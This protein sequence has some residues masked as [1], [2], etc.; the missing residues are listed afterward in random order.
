MTQT[1]GSG[2][3][4]IRC[5][6]IIIKDDRV[7]LIKRIK[8][9]TTYWVFPGGG[10]EQGETPEEGLKR[11]IYEELGLKVTSCEKCLG[12]QDFKANR[13]E[14]YFLTEVEDGKPKLTVIEKRRQSPD[15]RYELV[16]EN[17]SIL[18][19]PSVF[20]VFVREWV[21]EHLKQGKVEAAH[22]ANTVNNQ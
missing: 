6:A 2:A 20:P 17:L 21:K 15:N 18:D 16:W 7:L 10:L 11:E 3:K 13:E 8:P 1:S 22:F 9:D 12:F 4:R 14:I 19:N 5:G